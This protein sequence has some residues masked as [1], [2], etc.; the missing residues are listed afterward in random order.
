[1]LRAK[2][3]CVAVAIKDYLH[4][5]NNTAETLSTMPATHSPAIKA[6]IAPADNAKKKKPSTADTRIGRSRMIKV[7]YVLRAIFM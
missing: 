7:E 1:M 6:P 4:T 2:G 3:D 5:A